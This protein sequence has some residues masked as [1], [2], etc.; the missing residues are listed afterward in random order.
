MKIETTTSAEKR[1]IR[2]R[3][4][5][6]V[7]GWLFPGLLALLILMGIV[8][9][10]FFSFFF[11]VWLLD[12]F[13]EDYFLTDSYIQRRGA[14]LLYS[15]LKDVR[16]FLHWYIITDCHGESI[17]VPHPFLELEDKAVLDR[18]LGIEEKTN[19]RINRER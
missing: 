9:F 10:W 11:L 19:G 13:P 8:P 5:I 7:G 18:W 14:K 15:E 17:W 1:R 6:K 3:M 2:R 16:T 12:L 4:P